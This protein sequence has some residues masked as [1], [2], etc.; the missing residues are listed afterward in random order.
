MIVFY[1]NIRACRYRLRFD[2]PYFF[3]NEP[4]IIYLIK[5]IT[6]QMLNG[7][8]IKKGLM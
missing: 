8:L 2:F 5:K 6:S 3:T 1:T 7:V 4:I